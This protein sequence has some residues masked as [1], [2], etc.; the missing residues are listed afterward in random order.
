[1]N[2]ESSVIGALLLDNMAIETVRGIVEPNQFQ[3]QGLG[4]VYRCMLELADKNAPCDPLSVGEAI[5]SDQYSVSIGALELSDIQDSTASAAN[6]EYYA[7]QVADEHLKRKVHNL[8][9]VVADCKTGSEAI[10]LAIAELTQAGCGD[11]KT[12]SHINDALSEAIDEID[13]I[14]NERVSYVKSGIDQLDK[15]IHGF[16]GGGLYVIAGRPAMGKSVLALNVA[17]KAA[18]DGIATKV[19]SLEMPKKEVAYRIVCSQSSLN[20]RAKHDMQEEDWSKLIAGSGL[21]KDLPL[22]I[23]DGSGYSISYLKN[24]I[25]THAQ[26]HGGGLYVIDYLQL[27]SVKGEN[28]V[29][30][31]GEI[32]RSLKGL[33]KEIDSPIILLSQLN[34]GLE[35]RPD[36]RPMASDLRESGEI[37]QDSDVILML[38]RDE[39]YEPESSSKGIAELLI[40]KNRQGETGTAFAASRLEFSRFDNL[41][42]QD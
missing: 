41:A 5:L 26:K 39:V 35:S 32:T 9:H 40:R 24:S 6:V 8:G 1:M 7:E 20:T 2:F 38:Y 15:M 16:S 42:R 17:T 3:N 23:D 13:D 4:E 18:K 28:R 33:A 21:I 29:Q 11:N 10:E 37:E 36:K 31:I 22:E 12:T 14:F 19:Y 34:R 27:I 30:G 25:R